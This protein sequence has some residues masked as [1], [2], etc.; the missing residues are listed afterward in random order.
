MKEVH[1]LVPLDILKH[2]KDFV[3]SIATLID[4]C[5]GKIAVAKEDL[6]ELEKD[7]IRF[8]SQKEEAKKIIKAI[9]KIKTGK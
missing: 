9:E 8:V 2:S 7:L 5:K 6:K 3:E 1:H 4:A